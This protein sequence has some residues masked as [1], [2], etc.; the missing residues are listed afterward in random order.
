[1]QVVNRQSYV[2]VYE[3]DFLLG[4]FIQDGIRE[5]VVSLLRIGGPEKTEP[6][7]L[8]TRNMHKPK[9]VSIPANLV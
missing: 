9:V 1:M 5:Q 4:T 3:G 6:A 2:S 7:V 8:K